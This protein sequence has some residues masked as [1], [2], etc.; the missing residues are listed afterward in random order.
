MGK[1][2]AS[3]L[4]VF[5]ML[6]AAPAQQNAAPLPEIVKAPYQ[7]TIFLNF[8]LIRHVTCLDADKLE[9]Y[10]TGFM[11]KRG[12]MVTAAHVMGAVC[13][14]TV[15]RQPITPLAVDEKNDFALATVELPY[16]REMKFM[17]Y[18]CSGTTKDVRYESI[19][20]PDGGPLAMTHVIAKDEKT[21]E[22]YTL[23]GGRVAAGLRGFNGDIIPGMSGGPIVDEDGVAVAINSATNHAGYGMGRE[24]RDSI[25]CR[26]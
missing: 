13:W 5:F 18:S 6:G 26:H 19:G 25:L 1:L 4:S 23:T 2:I 9:H 10:G 15:T 17:R 16:P 20:Y 3:L 8:S 14:D 12:V 11:I 22:G 24:I 7:P 21:P